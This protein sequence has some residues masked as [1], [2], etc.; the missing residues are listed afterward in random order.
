MLT[1]QTYSNRPVGVALRAIPD[2]SGNDQRAHAAFCRKTLAWDWNHKWSHL[3]LSSRHWRQ[4]GEGWKALGW[5][6]SSVYGCVEV[7]IVTSDNDF[8]TVNGTDAARFHPRHL[9]V[10]CA[11]AAEPK[12]SSRWTR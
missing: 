6:P 4:L 5:E 9:A 3:F 8:F 11:P 1:P 7:G 2:V 10:W 12:P